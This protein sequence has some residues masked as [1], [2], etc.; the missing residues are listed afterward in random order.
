M[1]GVESMDRCA[2]CDHLV[3]PG[4]GYV[5]RIDLFADPELPPMTAQQISGA[6][7]DQALAQVMEQAKHMTA[8]ELQDGVHRRFSYRLCHA[9]HGKFL[10]NPLGMPRVTRP[11]E[12]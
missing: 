10:A 7:L 3:E 8:E 12:N 2:I 4:G 6:D 11:G 5:V 9:C 1:A